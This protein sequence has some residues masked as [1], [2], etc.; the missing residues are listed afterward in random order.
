MRVHR[1]KNHFP[2]LLSLSTA[3]CQREEQF[4]CSCSFVRNSIFRI[5]KF[6]NNNNNNNYNNN[7]NNNNDNNNNNNN[8]NNKNNGETLLIQPFKQQYPCEPIVAAHR[9]TRAVGENSNINFNLSILTYHRFFMYL[10][11]NLFPKW[12]Q[13]RF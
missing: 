13:S 4:S 5:S 11:I 7:D 1:Y 8:N 6:D 2:I 10:F 3:N 12:I 9:M